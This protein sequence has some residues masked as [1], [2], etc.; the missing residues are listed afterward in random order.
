[1]DTLTFF[2]KDPAGNTVEVKAPYE[3]IVCPI[4][5]G[6]RKNRGLDCQYCGGRGETATLARWWI[7]AYP[8]KA[9]G[10]FAY[11]RWVRAQAI[12]AKAPAKKRAAK[13]PKQANP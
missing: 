9:R 4:C 6:N 13:A 5:M 12:P 10:Y 1:M 3:H 7:E 11:Q 8:E 2:M